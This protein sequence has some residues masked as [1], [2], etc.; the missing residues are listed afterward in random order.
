MHIANFGLGARVG[1]EFT[2]VPMIFD[3]DKKC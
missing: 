2:P 3:I 1:E